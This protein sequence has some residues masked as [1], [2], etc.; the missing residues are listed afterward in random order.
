MSE[1]TDY[2]E[3]VDSLLDVSLIFVKEEVMPR[4]EKAL[5]EFGDGWYD[6]GEI[7]SREIE[8]LIC[9]LEGRLK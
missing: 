8:L 2:I 6:E 3:N 1:Y 5:C 7:H 9:A 4:V